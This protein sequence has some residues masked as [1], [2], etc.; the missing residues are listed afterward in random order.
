MSKIIE[1]LAKKPFVSYI[2]DERGEGN[3]IIVT[4]KQDWYWAD[5]TDCGVRGFDTVAELRAGLTNSSVVHID[6]VETPITAAAVA[7]LDKSL[8][9]VCAADFAD[10]SSVYGYEIHH[11]TRCPHCGT[12]LSNGVGEHLQEVN[13]TEIKHDHFQYA[14]LGCGAEFGPAIAKYIFM[15]NGKPVTPR[16]AMVASLKLDRRIVSLESGIVYKNACQVWKA[17]L[18]SSSQCDRLSALLYGAAKRGE[19]PTVEVNGHEFKLAIGA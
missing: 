6:T 12:H 4:L 13:G 16:P 17:D 7:E 18:V 5:E 1:R 19:F 2:D 8:P 3:S 11:L 9:G 10:E 14:C 15:H